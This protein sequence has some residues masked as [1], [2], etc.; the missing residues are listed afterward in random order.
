MDDKIMKW[1]AGIVGG[2]FITSIGYFFGVK[3]RGAETS[4]ILTES[5]KIIEETESLKLFNQKATLEIHKIVVVELKSHL[6]S[7]SQIKEQMSKEIKLLKLHNVECEE[8]AHELENR[9]KILES[10]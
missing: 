2:A 4:K 10:K 8:R 7:I 5:S 9:I 3:K 1:I 6:E